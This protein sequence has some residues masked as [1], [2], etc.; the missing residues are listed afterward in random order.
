[1]WYPAQNAV[2]TNVPNQESRYYIF[3]LGQNALFYSMIDMSLNDGLGGIVEEIKGIPLISGLS[4][5]MAAVKG[6]N[7]IWLVTHAK[8]ANIFYAIE[9][10]DTGIVTTP[11]VSE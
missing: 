8:D 11:V 6:C 9:I 5:K 10:N 2:I 7:C 4:E 3:S 1:G